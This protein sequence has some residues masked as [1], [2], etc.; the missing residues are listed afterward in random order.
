MPPPIPEDRARR[1]SDR[2]WLGA[3]RQYGAEG[4]EW[5]D[6]RMIGDAFTQAQVLETLTKENP[7]RFARLLLAIPPGTVEAYVGAILRGLAGARLDHPLLLD[8]CR[9]ARDLGGSDTN[10]WLVRLIET[11]AAGTLDDE[12]VTMVANVATGD[13]DPAARGRSRGGTA[14]ASTAPPSTPPEGL[15]CLLS[16]SS[17]TRTRP[18][19]PSSDPCYSGLS[20][21]RSPRC[22]PRPPPP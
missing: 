21:T 10:R 18:G 8:L 14:A 4:P 3:M 13:P 19:S 17:S 15:P 1:M 12:L 16:D 5:R 22:A 7:E 2:H 11:H 6:G 9:H 20:Q